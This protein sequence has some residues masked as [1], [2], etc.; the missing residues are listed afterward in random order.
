MVPNTV[1][2]LS[3]SQ[4]LSSF[5]LFILFALSLTF[6]KHTHTRI[7]THTHLQL[8]LNTRGRNYSLQ[9]ASSVRTK[10]RITRCRAD[11]TPIFFKSSCN[12]KPPNPITPKPGGD[13]LLPSS[14]LCS[15]SCRGQSPGSPHVFPGLL[16]LMV[17]VQ[18][19]VKLLVSSS[20]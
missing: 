11:P 14:F 8:K 19:V 2:G 9:S 1:S 13:R 17:Q 10:S 12:A 6:Y 18:R 15:S 7:H 3:V 5:V 20:R 16:L 4:S